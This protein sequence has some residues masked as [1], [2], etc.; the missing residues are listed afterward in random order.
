MVPPD[1]PHP[2][3][4]MTGSGSEGH[5]AVGQKPDRRNLSLLARHPLNSGHHD[6]APATLSR[7]RHGRA[8][9][10]MHRNN[11]RMAGR[12]RPGQSLRTDYGHG[13]RKSALE[14]PDEGERLAEGGGAA[15]THQVSLRTNVHDAGSGANETIDGLD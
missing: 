5:R 2:Y 11:R 3:A 4:G 15:A 8:H 10:L 12:L 14:I 1:V 9:G 6:G 13:T 7:K